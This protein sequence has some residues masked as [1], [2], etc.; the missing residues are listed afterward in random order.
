M[1]HKVTLTANL[2]NEKL[3]NGKNIVPTSGVK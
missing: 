2:T 1:S 3:I